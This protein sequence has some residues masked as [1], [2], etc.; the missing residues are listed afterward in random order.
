MRPHVLALGLS[1]C[2]PLLCG[3]PESDSAGAP[4][5]ESSAEARRILSDADA[6]YRKQTVCRATSKLDARLH[7][8]A[9]DPIESFQPLIDKRTLVL[10]APD[11]FMLAGNEF[12]IA[13]NGKQAFL[14][15]TKGEVYWRREAFPTPLAFG[16]SQLAPLFG[17]PD[18]V[19]VL[20]L[21]NP[22]LVAALRSE[23]DVV[24]YEGKTDI[25]GAPAH[26]L[27]IRAPYDDNNPQPIGVSEV[28]I[29]AEGDPVILQLK[30]S[31]A[32]RE[33][34]F[35]RQQVEGAIVSVET[36]SDWE[37]G[38]DVPAGEFANPEGR[39]RVADLGQIIRGAS[40]LVGK[41]AE[42]LSLMLLDGTVVTL[43][44]LQAQQKIVI[45]DFWATWC[46]PCRAELPFVSRLAEEYANE[47]VV[48]YG[49]NQME[50]AER[51]K[52]FQSQVDYKFTAALDLSG[53]LSSAFGA[54]SLPY[55]CIIGRDGIVQVVH[56]G[57]GADTENALREELTAL[58][59]GR[60]LAQEGLPE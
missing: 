46:G 52:S 18:N 29:A 38:G 24:S 32:P 31:P 20:G 44:E 2:L 12:R 45:L 58:V 35:G 28:W 23:T 17:G 13:S 59:S 1:L 4:T 53:E 54:G 48:F 30:H 49:V 9:G 50:S 60:N 16:D 8:R 42:D 6:F 22:G 40:P 15:P 19:L 26:H 25:E 36:F 10:H 3:C 51:I 34:Q 56:V 5:A 37:F 11:E 39:R 55:L 47:G 14:S 41:P 21:L 57:V 7:D 27:V 43:P 33:M